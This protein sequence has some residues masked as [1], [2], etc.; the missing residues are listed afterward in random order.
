MRKINSKGEAPAQAAP[1][2]RLSPRQLIDRDF[3]S[4]VIAFHEAIAAQLQMSAAEWKSLGALE[5]H[6]PL[7]AGRLAELSGFTTGAITGIVDRLERAGYVRRERH[8]SDRRS[9]II[10]PLR[11]HEVK[12]RVA[13]IF[14]SLAKRM[15]QISA[16]YTPAQLAAI[17]KFFAQTTDVLRGE[18][19]KLKDR[20]GRPAR[21][22]TG[23]T[24]EPLRRS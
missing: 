9:V 3:S 22:Q 11:L 4:A 7:T 10:H 24:R 23:K 8:P 16:A 1:L 17:Y 12:A 13:P 18:T 5:Q 6:G 19:A 14:G 15:A 20:A 2:D 21:K